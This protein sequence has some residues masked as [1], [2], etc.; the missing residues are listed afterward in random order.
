MDGIERLRTSLEEKY[1]LSCCEE[2]SSNFV[3]TVQGCEFE[4]GYGF[5]EKII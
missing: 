4:E 5:I 1:S 3:C 2:V